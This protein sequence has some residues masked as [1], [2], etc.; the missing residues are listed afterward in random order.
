MLE[1]CSIQRIGDTPVC[2]GLI[3]STGE[4]GYTGEPANGQAGQRTKEAP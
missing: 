4:T 3:L 1:C 2:N